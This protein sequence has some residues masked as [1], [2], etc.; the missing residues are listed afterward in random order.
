MPNASND[1]AVTS[2]RGGEE[3][4]V[5]SKDGSARSALRL[6]LGDLCRG[7]PGR[8]SRLRRRP[9]P[10]HRRGPASSGG[11]GSS[12]G[13]HLPL[14]P[15]RP[16]GG[17]HRR[18]LRAGPGHGGDEH[19]SRPRPRRPCRTRRRRAAS[20]TSC[21]SFSC[22]P[23]AGRG[24]STTR[25]HRQPCRNWSSRSDFPRANGVLSG[26]EAATEHLGGPILGTLAFAAVKALP[27]FGDAAAVGLS[28]LSLLGFRTE[29]LT[30]LA[31]P[32]L[33]PRRREA[34]LEGPLA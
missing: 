30:R 26:T 7:Q 29:A 3:S 24:R 31:R 22:S 18:P 27:F 15:A 1:A 9:P 28:G 2:D 32:P 8:R 5:A 13:G 10:R 17:R 20:T 33:D 34:A 6:P 11:V 25:R 16:A 4:G 12:R 19:G 23:T 21:S 14:A